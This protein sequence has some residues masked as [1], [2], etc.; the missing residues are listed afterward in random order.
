MRKIL[1]VLLLCLPAPAMAQTTAPSCSGVTTAAFTQHFAE[2]WIAAWNSHDLNRIL[3][4]YTDDFEMRSPLIIERMKEPSGTLHGKDKVRAYWAIGVQAQ[5]P[6]KFELLGAYA[7]VRSITIHY[8]SVGRRLATE[9]L[10]F[11]ASCRVVRGNA[12]YGGPA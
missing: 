6:L 9:V 10:E 3:E 5:P 11:N 4:H 7:G 1:P 8:R 12:M 2:D